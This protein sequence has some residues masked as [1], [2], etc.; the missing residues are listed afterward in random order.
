MRTPH[1]IDVALAATI[2]LAGCSKPNTSST[3]SRD[4]A[5]APAPSTSSASTS[6]ASTSATGDTTVRG[7]VVS[8]SDT[9]LTI[10]AAGGGDPV[11]STGQAVR[12]ALTPPVTVFAR[13]PA[14]LSKV[15]EHAFVGVTSVSQPDGSQRATEIHIF[16][17]EL[18]GLGEGSRPMGQPS[19]GSAS[20]MTNG[21]V[22]APNGASKSAP[23]AAPNAAPNSGSRMTNGAVSAQAGSTIT[24]QYQG[25]AQTI[26]VPSGVTVTALAPTNAALTP[27]QNVVV[28]AKRRPDGT[29]QSSRVLLATPRPR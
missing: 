12:V 9:V 15:S 10:G 8:V 14:D 16:P 5:A 24:V 25:G 29:L 7:T 27:G 23:N 26:V 2:I 28:L 17:E 11:S 18:R 21:T 20:T 3:T 4:S 6:P 19:G 13:Q 1:R 22:S